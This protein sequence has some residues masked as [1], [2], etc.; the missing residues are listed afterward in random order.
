MSVID[1]Y[2]GIKLARRLR[3]WSRGQTYA[4]FM[5][6]VLPTLSLIFGIISF[7]MAVYT[8]S[9]VS[10]A[11]RDAALRRH[12]SGRRGPETSRPLRMKI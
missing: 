9:F 2:K 6:V 7:A 3:G 4:E 1:T 10:N 12:R 11:S 5:M 8:Y